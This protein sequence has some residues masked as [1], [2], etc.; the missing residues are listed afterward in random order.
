MLWYLYF[1]AK[2]I[3]VKRKRD[4]TKQ[5]R[6][7]P[8]SVKCAFVWLNCVV[9]VSVARYPYHMYGVRVFILLNISFPC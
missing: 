6:T 2:F 4:K 5:N 1:V 9:A 3:S 8:S 7:E